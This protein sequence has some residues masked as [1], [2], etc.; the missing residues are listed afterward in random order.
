[1]CIKAN[2][3]P[4]LLFHQTHTHTHTRMMHKTNNN[5]K[6]VLV[7]VKRKDIPSRFLMPFVKTNRIADGF[8]NHEH[9]EEEGAIDTLIAHKIRDATINPMKPIYCKIKHIS[10]EELSV[11]IHEFSQIVE[12]FVVD[13]YIV[14]DNEMLKWI[15]FPVNNPQIEGGEGKGFDVFMGFASKKVADDN[16]PAVFVDMVCVARKI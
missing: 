16:S 9:Q 5:K 4:K 7:V 1:M 2:L 12:D 10:K 11:I 3:F 6:E 8:L 13:D 14:D 15:N